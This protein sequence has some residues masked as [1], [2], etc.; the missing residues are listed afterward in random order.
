MKVLRVLNNNVVLS[1]NDAGLEAVLS[2]CEV[3]VAMDN[4]P[5]ELKKMPDPGVEVRKESSRA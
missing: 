1:V 5:D 4:A 3:G 2:F